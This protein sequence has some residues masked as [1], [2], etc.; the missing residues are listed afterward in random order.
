MSKIKSIDFHD[1]KTFPRFSISARD[2]NILVGPNNAGKSTALDA[3]RISFDTLRYVARRNAIL[4]SQGEDGVCSTWQVPASAVQTDLRYCI[5]NFGDSR[6][7]VSIKLD[8]G[9]SFTILMSGDGPL[10][11][12]LKTGLQPRKS[13]QFLQDQFPL[14]LTIVPTLSPLEQNEELVQQETVEKNRYS[15]LASRNFRNFWLQKTEEEFSLFA[16][17]VEL[18]WP[19]IRLQRP[20]VERG[21]KRP[22]VRM[23]FR[24]GA[25]V[26]EVQWAGFGFQVWMQTMMHLA[27]AN[28]VSTLVL[29]EPDIYLHPD[30]QHRLLRLVG[31]RVGQYFIATHSTEIIN[32]A[33]A[34]EILIIRPGSRSAKRI[35]GESGYS[36]V[37][38]AI[39]SS[40]NAQFARLA[41]TKKVLYFE[42]KDAK[43]L[44]KIAKNLA[45]MDFISNSSVTLMKTDGFENWT[46]VTTSSWVFENFFEFKIPVCAIFDR[47]YRCDEEIS[48]FIENVNNED[49]LCRVLPRKEIEN[50]LLVPDAIARVVEKYGRDQL[51]ADWKAVVSEA[52]NTSLDEVKSKTLSARIGAR[53]SYNVEKKS[54]KDIGTISADEEKFFTGNWDDLEFRYRVVPGKLVFASIAKR[55]QEALK[56][57]VTASRVIDEMTAADIPPGIFEILK[58]VKDHLNS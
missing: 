50:L 58:E 31:Q 27:T 18:G 13:T 24:E 54:K 3:F 6:A 40:E 34:G 36:D 38:S 32:D 22:V 9:N 47:D 20:E 4:K 26:R 52:I 41:K 53:I 16:D 33:E 25:H 12:Y 56:V 10:E 1:Y 15:R 35:Q 5:H 19:G 44:S 43:I 21:S 37:Y 57:T 42:G 29:D 17:L 2:K 46:R 11:C 30:L 8:N 51:P 23:Y 14:N 45:G 49:T 48:D 28:H 39:G 7:R 55:I